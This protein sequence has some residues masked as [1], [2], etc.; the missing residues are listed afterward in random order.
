MFFRLEDLLSPKRHARNAPRTKRTFPVLFS[1]DHGQSWLPAYGLD[2][3]LGGMRLFSQ[4]PVP[5]GEVPLRVSLGRSVVDLRV[6]AAWHVSGHY[7]KGVGHEY[8]VQLTAANSHDR[9]M[10]E[11]W[12][13]GKPLEETNQAQEELRDI[14]LR[15]DDVDRLIPVAFQRRLFEALAQRGRLMPVDAQHPALV[16]YDYSGRV[17]YRGTAMHLLT[18]HSKVVNDDGEDRYATRVLFDD[19]GTTVVFPDF[20]AGAMSQAS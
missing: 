12:I 18:I 3:S 2:V 1:P 16:A 5:E 8:G 14:R 15:P 13:G 19:T 9:E 20:S 11:R 17:R 4:Q 7:K 10:L 6:K